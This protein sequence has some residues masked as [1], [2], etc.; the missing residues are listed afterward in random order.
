MYSPQKI[1]GALIGVFKMV[2]AYDVIADNDQFAVL[3]YDAPAVTSGREML[4][5][6]NWFEELTARV[7]VN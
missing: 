1:T 7:P 2:K 4:A 3:R 5:V 6:L